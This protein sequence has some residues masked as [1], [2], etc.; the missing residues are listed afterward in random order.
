MRILVVDDEPL[1]CLRLVRLL[2][3]L[4]DCEVV[5][6]AGNGQQAI[7]LWQQHQTELVLMDIR[8]PGMDG[9]AA[10]Q[11]LAQE[12]AP[13]AIIFCTAYNDYA[14]EAFEAEAVDYLLKPVTRDKLEKALNK[15]KRLNQLQLAAL[16]EAEPLSAHISARTANGVEL[17]P[18]REIDYFQAD[19]K[20]VTVYY[21]QGEVLIDDPL[22]ELEKQF[23][24][25]FIRVHRNAL[26]SVTAIRG[27]VK[28]DEGVRIKLANLE[29]G[30]L[31]SRRHLPA[32]RALLDKL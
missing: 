9:L 1:A 29:Q 15:A 12:A 8:M 19:Q 5:A 30:P 14:I 17:I 31:I 16:G 4:E 18:V 2:E 20:Y 3:G 11:A 10:A 28:C 27:L 26:V 21:R 32:V 25:G 22:K 7:D 13:P 23:A 24:D 6:E